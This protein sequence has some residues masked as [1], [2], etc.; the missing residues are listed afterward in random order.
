LIEGSHA[1][2][3]RLLHLCFCREAANKCPAGSQRPRIAVLQ[4]R[5]FA[6]LPV[7]AKVSPAMTPF[8]ASQ[9]KSKAFLR[10]F[11]TLQVSKINPQSAK[12]INDNLRGSS[13]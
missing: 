3:H 11:S 12:K 7:Y 13:V 2:D 9:A 6:A 5:S 8:D 1:V 4:P 10:Q